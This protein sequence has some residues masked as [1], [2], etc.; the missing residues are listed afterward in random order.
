MKSYAEDAK[1]QTR[2]LRGEDLKRLASSIISRFYSGTESPNARSILTVLRLISW[3]SASL[4]YLASGVIPSIP[5]KLI[6]VF[7]LLIEGLV[8]EYFYIL[9]AEDSIGLAALIGAET[10]GICVLLLPTGGLA[11]PFIWYALNLVF[12][13]ASLLTPAWCYG[14]SASLV[15]SA[16][17]GNFLIDPNFSLDSILISNA[18][19]L[20]SFV[21]LTIAAQQTARLVNRLSDVCHDLEQAQ[22]ITEGMAHHTRTL[23]QALEACSSQDNTQHLADLFASYSAILTG[24]KAGFCILWENPAGLTASIHDPEMMLPSV[25]TDLVTQD[26]NHQCNSGTPSS[27]LKAVFRF[28]EI[29]SED[30]LIIPLEASCI[31]WGVLGC[32][33][34]GNSHGNNGGIKSLQ[35]LSELGTIVIERRQLEDLSARLRVAEEQNRIANEIH[36]GVSQY[37]FGLSCGLHS[38]S[39][40]NG[41][42]QEE[43]VQKEF[44]LLKRTASHASRELRASIYRISPAKRGEHLF[45]SEVDSFLKDQA[46]LNEIKITF[47]PAGSED[48]VSPALRK[49]LFRLIREATSNAIRH[50]KADDI[51]ISLNMAPHKVNLDICDNGQGFDLDTQEKQGFPGIGLMSMKSLMD[52]FDGS[53]DITSSPGNG[54]KVSFA[55]PAER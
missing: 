30:F 36:D 1:S 26:F 39:T 22:K 10:I 9:W 37:L 20:F 49:A 45:I 27:V 15:L 11:S 24:S 50:G 7:G 18:F 8:A 38:L 43:A 17:F 28:P 32:F 31:N 54:T 48:A 52:T 3:F 23:Y 51:D 33:Q 13:A 40:Q 34:P 35:F 14:I 6:L 5:F 47:T 2:P 55:V 25:F 21:A 12:A 4:I 16:L 53:I 19:M 29:R 46:N 41:H 44:D 42:L